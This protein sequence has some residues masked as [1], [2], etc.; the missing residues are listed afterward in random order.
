LL[1]A[2]GLLEGVKQVGLFRMGWRIVE[3][4][5]MDRAKFRGAQ[6]P[7]STAPLRTSPT[8]RVA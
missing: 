6:Q 7:A 5:V 8:D 2:R 3:G 1:F 4:P